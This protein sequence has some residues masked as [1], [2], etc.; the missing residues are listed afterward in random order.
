MPKG[1]SA[2]DHL[3]RERR[4][5]VA[6][7]AARLMAQG[8]AADFHQAKRKAAERFGWCDEQFLPGNAEVEQQLREY[9]RLFQADVQPFALRERR[10]AAAEAM[11][12]LSRF[13]PRLVGPVLEG[14]AD[15][16][17]P[18]SLQLFTDSAEDV[19]FFLIESGIPADPGSQHLRLDREREQD[20]PSW[21]FSAD[22]LAFELVVLPT[23]LLRQAPL[24]PVDGKPMRRASLAA[25]Q[26]LLSEQAAPS[27]E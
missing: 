15:P 26:E 1:K 11:R 13:Q 18:I 8:A 17:S 14:T 22:G 19:A 20:V 21:H 16:N 9:Q 27:K 2:P 6:V 10:D 12:F 24:G 3:R 25:L 4:H 7:E 23:L 5:R